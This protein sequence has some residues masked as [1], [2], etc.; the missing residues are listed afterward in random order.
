MPSQAIKPP[1]VICKWE[2]STSL[3][4]HI[5]LHNPIWGVWAVVKRPVALLITLA[6][7]L[8]LW[9]AFIKWATCLFLD[10]IKV[11]EYIITFLELWQMSSHHRMFF[12]PCIVVTDV[13]GSI[14]LP[15]EVPLF[16]KKNSAFWLVWGE[17]YD[18]VHFLCLVFTLINRS[19]RRGPNAEQW[20]R[21]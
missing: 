6:A 11:C 7:L 1:L 17:K 8:H 19:I 14:C 13:M 3:V 9:P 20:N 21:L 15:T 4:H 16:V 2:S 18:F 12:S 5:S 10:A